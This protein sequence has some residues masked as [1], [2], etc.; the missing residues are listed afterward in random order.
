M[1]LCLGTSELTRKNASTVVTAV[2]YRVRTPM[3]S[4][5]GDSRM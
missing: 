3:N 4:A 2:G 5:S 1:K